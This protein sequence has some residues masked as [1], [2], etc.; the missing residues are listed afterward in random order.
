LCEGWPSLIAR[1]RRSSIFTAGRITIES[2][3]IAIRR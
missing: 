1:A 2:T 3:V